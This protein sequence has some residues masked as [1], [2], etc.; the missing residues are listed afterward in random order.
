MSI[1][2]SYDNYTITA[3]FRDDFNLSMTASDNFSGDYFLNE[4]VE[5]TKIKKDTI[6]ATLARKNEDHLKCTSTNMQANSVLLMLNQKSWSFHSSS[7]STFF[8]H[9]RNTFP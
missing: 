9:S 8:R 7:A 4:R 6:I 3:D 2:F 1:K 5:L